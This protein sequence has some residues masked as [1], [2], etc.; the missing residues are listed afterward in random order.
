MNDYCVLIQ[1]DVYPNGVI[2]SLPCGSYTCTSKEGCHI[3][4]PY[5]QLV[6]GTYLVVVTATRVNDPFFPVYFTVLGRTRA[7][8][9]ILK[10]AGE[11]WTNTIKLSEYDHYR[12]SNPGEFNWLDIELYVDSDVNDF[13][14][15]I[16]FLIHSFD[17][18]F[19]FRVSFIHSFIFFSSLSC[20]YFS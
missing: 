6:Q 8:N 20:A 14:G 17:S 18:L 11:K 4:I 1:L 2:G 15:I 16:S 10:V 7:V 3:P 12:I 5:C 9:T 19:F 13:P